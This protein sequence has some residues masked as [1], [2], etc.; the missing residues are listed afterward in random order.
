MNDKEKK[1]KVKKD[2]SGQVSYDND[3]KKKYTI[4]VKGDQEIKFKEDKPNADT[5]GD[6][7][8]EVKDSEGKVIASITK[9]KGKLDKGFFSDGIKFTE[10]DASHKIK[11]EAKIGIGS[12]GFRFYGLLIGGLLALVGII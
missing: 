5:D 8:V 1:I 6:V 11:G 3:D 4:V 12:F 10:L 2:K 7:N 9:L